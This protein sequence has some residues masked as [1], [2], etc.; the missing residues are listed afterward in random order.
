M[1]HLCK[2]IRHRIRSQGLYRFIGYLGV[3]VILEKFGIHIVDIY[4]YDISNDNECFEG[5][6]NFDVITSI[7]SFSSEDIA[8]LDEYGGPKL[9]R[10]FA[11]R[12]EQDMKAVVLRP[13]T[14]IA[15]IFWLDGKR[16]LPEFLA[17]YQYTTI[18][19]CFT[20]P[21][22]RGRGYYTLGLKYIAY[23]LGKGA[24]NLQYVIV[25]CS[26]ANY[27]SLKGIKKADFYLF[28]KTI[29]IFGK[30]FFVRSFRS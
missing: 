10:L 14:T 21:S 7:G 16:W 2:K 11:K 26:I 15:S 22:Y 25:E 8:L 27:S 1:F 29:Q 23:I 28:K 5:E 20:F 17:D 3:T 19:D 12:F 24:N 13:D 9:I 6:N 30:R 18:K 4:R